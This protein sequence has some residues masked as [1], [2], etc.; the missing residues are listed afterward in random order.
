[1]SIERLRNLAKYGVLTDPD[2]YDLPPEAFSAGVNVRFR[3]GRVTGGPVFRRALTFN[4][5]ADPRYVFSARPPSG[6]DM[7]FVGYR[8]GHITLVSGASETIISPPSVAPN[9][10]EATWSHATL[11]SVVYSNRSDRT[12]WYYRPSDTV[13]QTLSTAGWDASWRC[14]LLRTCAGALVALNVT[15]GATASPTMVKTSSIPLAGTVPTSWDISQP[16]T[17][18]TEN[19]LAEMQGAIVDAC[20][21]GNQLCIYGTKESWMMQADGSQQ[22]YSYR[23]LPF[24]KGS[25]NANCSFELDGKN[26]VFGPDDIWVH[27]GT[28]EKSI[29]DQQTRDFIYNSLNLSQASRCFV[30]HNPQLKELSFAY[31]SGDRLVAFLNSP[32]GCN[33]QAVF[34]YSTNVWTFDDLPMVFGATNANLATS[35]TYAAAAATYETAGGSYLDQED[36]FKRTPVYI[37]ANNPSYGLVQGLYAFDL[38]GAG[39]TSSFPVD[40]AAT[41]PRY[42]ERTGIDLDEIA[43][44]L[45]GYKMIRSIF[46]QARLGQGA[47]PLMIDA[48]AAD[49]FGAEPAYIGY[50]PYDGQSA[51]KCDFNAAGRWLTIR[52]KHNDYKELSI[53]GFDLDV[54]SLGK[55]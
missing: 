30:S 50:Q 44:E 35:L 23:K 22:V 27:D 52:M 4:V 1:M 36:G 25:L 13:F 29:C 8:D 49:Y 18:A 7:L 6:L 43:T 46:P 20:S 47:A 31:V 38:Y 32:D 21:L 40:T 39:S 37:G 41:R 12:P 42:L 5:I 16:N 11:A 48:G 10:V 3:N 55:R 28:S 19:I 45:R 17:L 54:A 14:Q 9:A 33:R 24:Q 2:P 51:Y 26:Y 53:S 34:N 15:K